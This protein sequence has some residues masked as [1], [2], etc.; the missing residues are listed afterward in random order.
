M[1]VVNGKPKTCPSDRIRD[2]SELCLS[3][4]SATSPMKLFS[5]LFAHNDSC[6]IDLVA[7]SPKTDVDGNPRI[8]LQL[9]KNVTYPISTT[10]SHNLED[11][12]VLSFLGAKVLV[13]YG[14]VN[15]KTHKTVGSP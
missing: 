2:N 10:S 4:V 15:S 7:Y 9:P 8:L 6:T 5:P 14:R 13:S 12:E 11:L 1:A 3:A